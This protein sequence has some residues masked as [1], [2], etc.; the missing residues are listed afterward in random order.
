VP[1]LVGVSVRTLH[2]YDEIN[3]LK[4]TKL[5]EAGYR[6]YTNDDLIILQQ[7]LLFRELGVPPEGIKKILGS[8]DYDKHRV[9]ECQKQLLC[10]KR[11]R[12]NSLMNQ[13]DN[14]IYG[15]YSF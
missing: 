4:P 14:M 3:L 9:L 12:L 13:I 10:V 1:K 6:L 11:N 7:I 8:S 5:T 2:Y 15:C